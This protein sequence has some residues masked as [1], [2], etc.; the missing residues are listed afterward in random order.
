MGR[1][2]SI[3]EGIVVEQIDDATLPDLV[4]VRFRKIAP[5]RV[6]TCADWPPAPKSPAPMRR[7][8]RIYTAVI[9]PPT[10]D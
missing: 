9:R 8:A 4:V 5:K 2:D 7:S 6:G 3:S 10:A 1:T